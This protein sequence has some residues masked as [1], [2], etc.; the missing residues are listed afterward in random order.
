MS[1]KIGAKNAQRGCEARRALEGMSRE[2]WLDARREGLGG[3]DAAVI[4][5]L[6]P[7]RSELALWMDKR[8]E[9]PEQEPSEAMRLGNELEDY[10]ARR[11][12]EATGK[13]VRRRGYIFGNRGYP[14][15]LANVDREV[16]GENAALECKTTSSFTQFDFE[17][18]EI[19]P[20][21][22]CQCVHY[23]AVCGYDRMYLAVLVLGRGFYH[24]RIERD[25]E[26]IAALMETERIW[27]QRHM[28]EGEMPDPDGSDSAGDAL[29][30]L[31]PRSDERKTCLLY[32]AEGKLAQIGQ[33]D[34]SIK[35]MEQEKKALQ[36]EIQMQMGEAEKGNADGFSVTW[37]LQV[38]RRVDT[39]KLKEMYPDVYA[40]VTRENS[41]R[42]FRIRK[43]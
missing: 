8:G 17:N 30:Q 21:Y 3:S 9:L 4:L 2:E 38:S 18:G 16:I 11:W 41:S 34:K 36:Q 43:A 14:F 24:F 27:W 12:M 1:M 15:A 25:E 28:I 19:P 35:E 6:S 33:L 5:G 32:G 10:V 37:K 22:Y 39:G 26:E 7:F 31:F 20:Y 42:V 40:R 23:M 29:R 13:K